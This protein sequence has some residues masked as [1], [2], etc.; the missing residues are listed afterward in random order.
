MICN[1]R[2]TSA[3][4][5]PGE[6]FFDTNWR[7][8]VRWRQGVVFGEWREG[9]VMPAYLIQV[10]LAV[11]PWASIARKW[12][13]F[14]LLIT[15]PTMYVHYLELLYS[16]V[17]GY[18]FIFNAAPNNW[19]RA[20]FTG[21]SLDLLTSFSIALYF[22]WIDRYFLLRDQTSPGSKGSG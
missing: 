13:H 16:S 12:G 21:K 8:K 2:V 19:I 14:S 10:I 1:P 3:R 4:Y 11:I 5:L 20:H 22:K 9:R 6:L 7:K 17:N 15:S 18:L